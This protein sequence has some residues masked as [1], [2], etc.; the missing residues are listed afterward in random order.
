[1]QRE[2]ESGEEFGVRAYIALLKSK[3]RRNHAEMLEGLQQIPG[4]VYLEEL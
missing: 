4:V 3:N 1:M 2:Q